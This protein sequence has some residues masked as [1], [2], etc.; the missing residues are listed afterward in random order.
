MLL[1]DAPAV[2]IGQTVVAG[3]TQIGKVR[4]APAELAARLSAY[5]HDSGSHVHIQVTQEPTQ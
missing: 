1:V 5:T 4:E 3:K 2:V